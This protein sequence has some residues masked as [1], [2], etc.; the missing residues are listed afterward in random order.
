[1]AISQ[2]YVLT[3][4]FAGAAIFGRPAGPEMMLIT[5]NIRLVESP[6]GPTRAFTLHEGDGPGYTLT[7]EQTAKLDRLL[8]EIEFKAP[9]QAQAGFDGTTYEL[10]LQGAMSSVTFRWWIQAPPEWE[11]VG[12][13]FDYV[14][15]VADGYQ[16]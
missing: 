4:E 1:M 8:G 10:V 6:P 12:A 13:L 16:T 7:G 14:L 11:Q 15:K 5:R 2:T 9:W 3:I